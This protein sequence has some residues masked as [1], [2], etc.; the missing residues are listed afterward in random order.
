M[1]EPNAAHWYKIKN[2]DEIDTPALVVYPERVREN[3]RQLKKMSRNTASLRPHVK[4][5]KT[6]EASRM[7]LE[8]GI[9]KFK[10]ATIAEAE[11]L[12]MAGAPDVLL[13]YQPTGPK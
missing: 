4:T 5:H 6:I 11:M 12:G 3:I 9:S 1:N 10:C 7:L 2:I 13:A 8:E